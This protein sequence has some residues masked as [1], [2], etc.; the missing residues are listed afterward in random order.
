MMWASREGTGDSTQ[1]MY[2]DKL[3]EVDCCNCKYPCRRL[4]LRILN[5]CYLMET[6]VVAC[7]IANIPGQGI[8]VWWSVDVIYR[9]SS[10]E[11]T[12]FS[13]SVLAYRLTKTASLSPDERYFNASSADSNSRLYWNLDSYFGEFNYWPS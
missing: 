11:D 5:S 13:R 2:K 6:S 8:C 4:T 3:Y 12:R 9:V 10:R 1:L 7:R